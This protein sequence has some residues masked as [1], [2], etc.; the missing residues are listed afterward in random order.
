MDDITILTLMAGRY[1]CLEPYLEALENM[2]YP[3]KNIS[4]VWASNASS[5]MYH[6]VIAREA[7]KIVD[8]YKSVKVIRL[9]S[10][11]SGRAFIENGTG[12]AE[13]GE[14]I[15]SLYNEAIK[16]VTTKLVCFWEDD[17]IPPS[18]GLKRLLGS[19]GENTAVVGSLVFDRHCEQRAMA[20]NFKAVKKMEG[21]GAMRIDHIPEQVD[22]LWGVKRVGAVSQSFTVA[23]RWLLDRINPPF[24]AR[25]AM[26]TT[27][28]GA[29]LVFCMNLGLMGYDILLDC[30]V[31]CGHMNSKGEVI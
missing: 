6:E 9:P 10:H 17:V 28:V 31:R 5:D 29:D 11:T 2:D 23:R 8:K 19:M 3:K 21:N 4:I 1:D 14:V 22:K 24:Q 12:H 27:A 16:H 20:W 7:E 25:T 26:S 13:H 18:H 30:D 15:A